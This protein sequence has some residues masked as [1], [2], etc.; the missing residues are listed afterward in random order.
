MRK[1]SRN[2]LMSAAAVFMAAGAHAGQDFGPFKVSD[3]GS[4]KVG[5]VSCATVHYDG[6]WGMS[7]PMASTYKSDPGYP[8]SSASGWTDKG[9]FNTKGGPFVLE[10]KYSPLPDGSLSVEESVSSASPIKTNDLAFS[11]SL[12]L[13]A[14]A[15]RTLEI[16]AE[17]KF[18]DAE[19]SEEKAIFLNKPAFGKVLIPCADSK[20]VI[21]GQGSVLLQ[22]N[23]KYAGV[24]CSLRFHFDPSNGE[25]SSS[26]ISL[27]LSC[28]PYDAKALDI[29]QAMNMGF[30]DDVEG[31][32]K[33]GWT[34]QGP[35]NDLHMIKPGTMRLSGA[36]FAILDPAKNGGK[37]CIVLSGSKATMQKAASVKFQDPQSMQRLCLLHASAWTPPGGEKVGVMTVRYQDGSKAELPVV[38]GRQVGNWWTPSQLPD[39]QLAWTGENKSSFVGLYIAEFKVEPKP[40]E[41]LDFK[42]EGDSIWMIV[43]ASAANEALPKS[44]SVPSYIVESKDWRPLEFPKRDLEKGSALDFSSLLDA[45][46]GKYGPVVIRGG[47]FEYEGK[48]GAQSRFYGVNLCFAANFLSKENSESLAK[49][50]SLSGYNSVRF[51]HFDR[52]LSVKNQ[53]STA[54]LDP[55]EMDKLDYLFK[56]LKDRGIYITIDLFISRQF[57][58]GEIP[59]LNR[60]I[61]EHGDFKA[62][63][64]ILDSAMKNFQDFSKA[65]LLHVNPYTGMA[66][67]DDPA[68]LFISLV[69]EDNIFSCW[70]DKPDIK[71]IYEAKFEEW[72]KAKGSSGAVGE[73][74][75]RLLNAFLVETYNK[76][77]DKMAAFVKSIGCKL[78]L[79]DQNMQEDIPLALMRDRYDYVDNHFYWDH[80]HFIDKPWRLPSSI[81]NKSAIEGMASC[82]A[83]VFQSRVFGKPYTITEFN[84][85]VPCSFRAESGPLTGAYAALQGWDALY[86]FAWSHDSKNVLDDSAS[87]YFDAASDPITYLSDKIGLALYLR[88]DVAESKLVIPVFVPSNSLERPD[89]PATPRFSKLGARLGLVGKVGTVVD[90]DGK[91][92]LPAGST[93]SLPAFYKGSDAENLE[94]I[95]KA[96]DFGKGSLDLEA[97]TAK[98]STG[99]IEL[100]AVAKSFKVVTSRSEAF[101][102]ADKGAMA[103]DALSVS[104]LTEGPATFFASSLDGK[105][106]KDSSRILILHLT[107]VENSKI[108]FREAQHSVLESWGTMPHLAKRGEAELKLKLS[109]AK[110]VKVYALDLAGRRMGEVKPQASSDGALT[111]RLDSFAFKSP[112]FA[113]E[114]AK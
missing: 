105:P 68:L 48:P 104:S 81:K 79:T 41:G 50:L 71:A 2:L 5:G 94:A 3:D 91:P 96:S 7:S 87:N 70:S 9:V 52:Q 27:K 29:S 83:G 76:G 101:V 114:I 53:P 36:P 55:V 6:Q 92:A 45:P 99:E 11:L 1:I 88:G 73:A 110:S 39:A 40:I 78:P 26:K 24:D 90:Y 44:L 49:L 46:A 33:G 100:D 93:A 80:P 75:V 98:S 106:L 31:D 95:R 62:S 112:C 35:D 18:I 74:R 30:A 16:G 22:D 25:V 84:W 19:T 65:L 113:Y 97:K 47:R 38:S 4:I 58:K 111:L 8:K 103:G 34:D 109:D 42:S 66:W 21:E 63:V 43:A 56:C 107:E 69:N 89:S 15:G 28:V 14:F 13:A 85:A 67:K 82:P 10:R 59:E 51:H 37:G 20:L 23:R 77:Y 61:T 86:R 108:K 12:P 17:K 102:L 60:E 57:K 54:G 32:G 64:F 72:L